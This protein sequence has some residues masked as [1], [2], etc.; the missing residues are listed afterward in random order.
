MQSSEKPKFPAPPGLVASLTAGFDAVANHVAVI[1]LPILLDL[2][3]WL[4]PHVYLKDLMQPVLAEMSSVPLPATSG[5]PDATTLQQFWNSFLGQFNLLSFLRTYPVGVTSLMAV[6]MPIKTPL[7]LPVG[8]EISSLSGLLAASAALLVIGLVAGSLFLQQIARITSPV[9]L[10]QP[11]T[12]SWVQAVLVSLIWMLVFMLVIPPLLLLF[13]F[14][15][16]ISPSLAQIGTIII[17]LLA[18]WVLA[19]IFFS[20]HGV[21]VFGQNAPASIMQSVRMMRFSLPTSGL[22]LVVSLLISEGLNYL[23]RMPPDNSWL[24]LIG[25]AGHAFISTALLAASFFYYRNIN[26]WLKAVLEQVSATRMTG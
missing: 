21:F 20:P 26:V 24:T 13:T 2:L 22:F 9:D 19:P 15:A 12:R 7:G 16:L 3:L 10:N 14:L 5:L 6:S 23:W 4:G 17:L 25:I 8:L 1:I 18:V 11:S